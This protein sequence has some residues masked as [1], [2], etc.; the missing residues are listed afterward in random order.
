MLASSC[1]CP[2]APRAPAISQENRRYLRICGRT[3]YSMALNIMTSLLNILLDYL[4][5]GVLRLGIGSAALA[6]CICL[7]YSSRC[8]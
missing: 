3:H 4:F 5:L 2:E 7:L 1:T 6:S 8:V